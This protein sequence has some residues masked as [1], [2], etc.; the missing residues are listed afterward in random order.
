MIIKNK[1]IFFIRV[2]P[3]SMSPQN[4]ES[5]VLHNKLKI[6]ANRIFSI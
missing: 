4:C 6:F 3:K 2:N 5:T 1:N